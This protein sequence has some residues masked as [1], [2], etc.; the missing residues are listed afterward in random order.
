MVRAVYFSRFEEPEVLELVD[1]P[2]PHPCPRPGQVRA[3]PAQV[4]RARNAPRRLT[5]RNGQAK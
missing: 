4:S 2:D 1:L 3:A 5:G